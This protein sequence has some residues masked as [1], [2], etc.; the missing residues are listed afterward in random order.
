MQARLEGTDDLNANYLALEQHEYTKSVFTYS[1]AAI[2][3]P[4]HWAEITHDGLV[5]NEGTCD[6][7]M[8]KSPEKPWTERK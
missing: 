7:P 1:L 6:W 2:Q 3:E 4:G 8:L 5:D